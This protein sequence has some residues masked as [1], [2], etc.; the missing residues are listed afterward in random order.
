MVDKTDKI[1]VDGELVDWDQATVHVLTHTLHYGL[2]VFE[3]IRCYRQRNGGAAVFRLRE[4]IERLFHSAAIATIPLAPRTVD[5]VC[6]A[7][8]QTI[9]ANGLE[10]C[11]VRPL[12]FLGAGAM[13][14]G[15]HNHTHLVIAVWPWGAYLGDEGYRRGIRAKISSFTRAPV[16]TMMSKAK[17]VGNYVNSILAH[18]EVA[19]AGYDEAILLDAQGHVA[20][21]SGENLFLVRGGR[22]VTPPP[23]ASILGGIT[24]DTVLRLLAENGVVVQERLV[25]RDELYTA[26]EVF[27]VGTAAEVTPVREIDDRPVGS[28]ER[29]PWTERLQTRYAEVVRGVEPPDPAWLATVPAHV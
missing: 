25:T 6:E 12:A 5:E 19:A 7:C 22:F 13:G 11:Y 8:L 16:N 27:L 9:A 1:W 4:H 2:G 24:R 14:L 29:G 21:G 23:G 17:I 26:D 18:R 3:G 28:G 15:A 10:E 20:E